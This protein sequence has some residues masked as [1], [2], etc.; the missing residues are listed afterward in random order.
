MVTLFINNSAGTNKYISPTGNQVTVQLNRPIELDDGDYQLQVLNANICYCIPNI[1]TSNNTLKYTFVDTNSVVQTKTITFDI[2]L[3]AINDIN[4]TISL[5]TQLS[6]NGNN[7]TLFYF[8]A[9][10]ATSKALLFFTT[11]HITIDCSQPNSIMPTLGYPA[12]AG[13]IG[14]MVNANYMKPPNI[15][16][17]NTIQNILIKCD[18][19]NGSYFNTNYSNIIE[20]VTPDVA[21]YSTIIYR[22]FHPIKSNVNVKRIDQLTITLVDQDNQNIDMGSNGGTNIPELFSVVLSI[23]PIRML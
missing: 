15:V 16:V 19:V 12:S 18:I 4:S 3:Y 7:D 1:T 21:P 10:E 11:S 8:Q 9:D 13:I 2:G 14:D 23:E 20:C 5:F 22:P 17:L 6:S